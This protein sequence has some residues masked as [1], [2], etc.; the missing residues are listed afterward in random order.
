MVFKQTTQAFYIIHF[1]DKQTIKSEEE[2]KKVEAN[3][4]RESEKERGGCWLV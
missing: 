3:E 4:G 1:R 2:E